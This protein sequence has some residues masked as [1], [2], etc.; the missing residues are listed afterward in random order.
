MK[1]MQNLLQEI[2]G[3]QTTEDYNSKKTKKSASKG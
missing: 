2:I 1:D 3:T